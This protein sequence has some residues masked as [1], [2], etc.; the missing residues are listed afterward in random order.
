MSTA[1]KLGN[2]RDAVFR[3]VL[4]SGFN[5]GIEAANS[6]LL[7]SGVNVRRCNIGVDLRNSQAIFHSSR[8]IDNGI[9]VVVSKSKAYMIDTIARRVLELLPKGEVRINP[10][11]FQ[12]LAINVINTRNVQE[13]RRRLRRLL[14]SLKKYKDIWTIYSIIREIFRLVGYHI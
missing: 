11:Q 1:I 4:I 9:D 12:N 2:V 6:N 3:N 7:L 10:Y 14:D 5:K 13:K 8:L